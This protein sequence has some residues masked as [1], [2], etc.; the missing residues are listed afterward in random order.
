[1]Q[2]GDLSSIPFIY[3][4]A[5]LSVAG[6]NSVLPP[7]VR[8][9]F[10]VVANLLHQL[11]EV[12]CEHPGC[13][14][15]AV[16]HN[17]RIFLN[18]YFGFENF[19]PQ[20]ALPDGGSLQEEIVRSAAKNQTIFATLPTGGG[21]SLCYLLPALMRYQRRNLL[22][23]VISPLQALMKDQVDNF[24]RQTGTQIA[25]ALSGMLTMPERGTVH[26]GIRL[27]DIGIIYVS[28]EQLRK[29]VVCENAAAA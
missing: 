15:C 1:M 2:D 14:Y 23:V 19:R 25:A 10:P 7:W 13:E 20:P 3:I 9:R 18:N 17:P 12:P 16:N 8:K 28:P 11:R 24:S 26:E 21:K 27:G 22:T 5:W 29:L 6:G 4:C